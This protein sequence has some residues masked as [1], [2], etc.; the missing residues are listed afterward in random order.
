MKRDWFRAIEIAPQMHRRTVR[1]VYQE[2]KRV[3][4]RK[5]PEHNAK[6]TNNHVRHRRPNAPG[7]TSLLLGDAV[8]GR[9]CVHR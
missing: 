4:I 3:N 1:R 7:V 8:I 5:R 6:Q 2:Q 9:N